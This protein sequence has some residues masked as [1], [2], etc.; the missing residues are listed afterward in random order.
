MD[1]TVSLILEPKPVLVSTNGSNSK[2]L[3]FYLLTCIYS[4]NVFRQCN[5]L[6]HFQQIWPRKISLLNAKLNVPSVL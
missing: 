5:F 3:S 4:V 1:H 2:T 6:G